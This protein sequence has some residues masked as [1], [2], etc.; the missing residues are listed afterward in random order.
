MELL[1]KQHEC[2]KFYKEIN[3]ARKQVKPRVN[4][5]TSGNE[6]GSLI[7]NGQ[8]TWVRY[9]DKSLNRR[10]DNKCYSYYHKQ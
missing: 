9:F 4:I 5:C 10:K 2:R 6:E 7:S 8:G 1:R 3:M